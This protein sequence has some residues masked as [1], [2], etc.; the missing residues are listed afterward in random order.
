MNKYNNKEF[1]EHQIIVLGKKHQE[2]ATELNCNINTLKYWL[3]QHNIK[4]LKQW[5]F[6]NLYHKDDIISKYQN[7]E[8]LVDIANLYGINYDTI[9]NV[10]IKN[11]VPLREIKEVKYIRDRRFQN[12]LDIHKINNRLFTL[13]HNYFKNWSEDMAYILG[14]IYADG[15]VKKTA[16]MIE[17]NNVDIKLLNEI[18]HKLEYTGELKD[19]PKTRS[20]RLVMKSCILTDDLKELGVFEN[21]SKTIRMPNVPEE[22]VKDFIRGVFD[23]DGSIG[24]HMKTQIRVRFHSG[25]KLFL[26]DLLEAIYNI[27]NIEK[28]K[29]SKD[30]RNECYSICYSTN[31]SKKF[32]N[33]VYSNDNCMKC[34]R[35]YNTFVQALQNNKQ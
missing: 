23:G 2:L 14:F 7:N 15:C 18:K 21:K 9:R 22:Y 30:S 11:N 35:K 24:I 13:N 6:Y 12:E 31:S 20:T 34:E 27:F 25:S 1:L 28:V 16:L 17:L 10:L 8:T 33:Y 3:K 4:S 5:E 32:F 19:R 29:I 26:E